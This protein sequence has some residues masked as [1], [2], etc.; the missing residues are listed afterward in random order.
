M[1]GKITTGK[2]GYYAGAN[3]TVNVPKGT[4]VR[5]IRAYGATGATL[6][7]DGG[8]AM[9]LPEGMLLMLDYEDELCGPVLEFASTASY[10]VETAIPPV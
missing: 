3:G 4:I 10:Y 5:K 9:P 2:F 6:T 7:I 8:A 1:S